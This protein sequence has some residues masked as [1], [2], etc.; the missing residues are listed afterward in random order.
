MRTRILLIFGLSWV[1][2][3]A[4]SDDPNTAAYWIDRLSDKAQ[5]SEALKQLGKIGD[6]AAVPE[7][8]R[9]LEKEG[10]WQPDAAYALGQL[11]D[12]SAVPKLTAAIDYQALGGRDA[13]SRTKHRININVARALAMLKAKDAAERVLPLLESGEPTVR[14]ATIKALGDLGNPAATD[15]LVQIALTD[16]EPFLRKV[17][18]QALG[19]L[20]DAKAVPALIQLLYVEMPNV[21]FYE[22]ARYALLQIGAP[23]IPEL[24]KTLKRENKAV[25]NLRTADGQAIGEGA[26]EAKAASVL[27]YLKAKETE[28]LIVQALA[29]QHKR[30][31]RRTSE[32]VYASVPGS[33]IEMSYALGNLGTPTAV[34][35]LMPVASDP[36]S[37]IRLA[38]AEA[39]TQTGERSVVPAL[40]AAARVGDIK[41]QAAV[42][43]AASRLGQSAHL[44]AFDAVGR[45][46]LAEVTKA[47]RVRLVAAG[48]CKTDLACWRQ[49]LADADAKVREKAVWELGWLGGKDALVDLLKAAED[50][51]PVVRMAAVLSMS[52][53]GEVDAAKLQAIYD[54]WS[55]K[56][57][58]QGVN[59]ELRR[60]IA[61][62]SR[63]AK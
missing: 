47:E 16:R 25:E 23:A 30:Y 12:L 24:V 41:G 50:P 61:R 3:C 56:L 20:G 44:A 59:M 51:D 27:G 4:K 38:A 21:S 9:W 18:V 62:L 42:L 29:K 39:L 57:D 1:W 36:D 58:Y 10:D 33:I 22:E 37:S 40:I 53:V 52:R 49:K 63:P 54:T 28:P 32:P 14:E 46:A 26:V 43:S 15:K 5:R 17:A 2:A 48:E 13:R 6:Q 35:A 8:V 60:L 34:K 11:G 19:V 45:G 31:Q 55:K 7:V